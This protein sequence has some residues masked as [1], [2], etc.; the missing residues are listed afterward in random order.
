MKARVS[1][2]DLLEHRK[3]LSAVKPKS[4]RLAA[5]TEIILTV[6][7]IFR[8]MALSVQHDIPCESLQW[9]TATLPFKT[10]SSL[11]KIASQSLIG[12][13]I[14]IEAGNGYILF[15]SIRIHHP[16]IKVLPSNKLVSEIPIDAEKNQ[17]RSFILESHTIEQIRNS[18]LWGTY[19]TIVK[20]ISSDMY[21]AH[22]HLSA[23]GVGIDD[24]SQ[25]LV[26]AL[27]VKDQSLFIMHLKGNL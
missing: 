14:T 6:S 26:N 1:K 4:A 3:F 2:Q 19:Q 22:K 24:M 8:V 27:K 18:G 5:A 21:K 23:Y 25:I 16:S 20:E 13:T 17:I 7:D 15:D 11:I 9:G 10:W 12:E